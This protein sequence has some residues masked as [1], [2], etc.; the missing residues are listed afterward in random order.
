MFALLGADDDMFAKYSVSFLFFWHIY[1]FIILLQISFLSLCS[2]LL[3][4]VQLIMTTPLHVAC[5]SHA[6]TASV[7]N[8]AQAFDLQKFKSVHFMLFSLGLCLFSLFLTE[9]S[10]TLN[11]NSSQAKGCNS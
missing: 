9:M 2:F 11:F 8:G 6:E 5:L 10:V 1:F 3:V 7:H 4:T